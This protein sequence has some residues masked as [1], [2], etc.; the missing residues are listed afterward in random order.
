[1]HPIQS[2][3][4]GGSPPR[5]FK[6]NFDGASRGNPGQARFGG[7]VRDH[8]GRIRI[9][10]MGSIGEDT[11]NS[12]KLEGL[13]HGAEMLIRRGFLPMIIEGDSNILIS[14]AKRLLSGQKTEK[15]SLSWRLAYR[16]ECL[17]VLLLSHP[18]TS[19]HHVRREANKVANCLANA[20]VEC[21]VGFR[22]DRLDVFAEEG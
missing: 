3:F 5:V 17:R 8:E 1:M 22:C 20:G 13:L 7:L 4:M 15:I 19:F 18:A 2:F 12:A 6:L 14:A 10:F 9:V 16:L 11:N 21:G